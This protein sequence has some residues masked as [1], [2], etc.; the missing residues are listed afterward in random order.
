MRDAE[1]FLCAGADVADTVL[2]HFLAASIEV[3][4]RQKGQNGNL[5]E[6]W[7][8]EIGEAVGK[9]DRKC[10]SAKMERLYGIVWHLG[11]IEA[12]EQTERFCQR[13]AAGSIAGS[14]YLVVV[15]RGGKSD[16]DGCFVASKV[17]RREVR[18]EAVEVGDDLLRG[19]T[20]VKGAGAF[21]GDRFEGIGQLELL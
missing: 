11:K 18:P 20:F 3:G 9:G 15:V 19:G 13:R 16:V 7:V 21:P 14:H 4:V 17:V 1:L 5:N 8:G 2:L 10:L 12:V 6:G